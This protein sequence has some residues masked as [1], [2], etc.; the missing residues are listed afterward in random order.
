MHNLTLK[1]I[2][3][4]CEL[5]FTDVA[6]VLVIGVSSVFSA[7]TAV[8]IDVTAAKTDVTAAKADATAVNTV[9]TSNFQTY[10]MTVFAADASAFA[11]VTSVFTAVATKNTDETSITNTAATSVKFSSHRSKISF[12]AGQMES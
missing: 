1:D 11:A 3:L 9:M 4:R 7:A 10:V 8:K 12:S 2:L 5:N 6:A